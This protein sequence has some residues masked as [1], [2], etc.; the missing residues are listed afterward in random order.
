[1]KTSWQSESGGF[2]RRWSD[3]LESDQSTSPVV[4]EVLTG[5][6]E[7]F[8]PPMPDLPHIVCWARE[9]GS[10]PGTI[11]GAYRAP[12]SVEQGRR[13]SLE[14]ERMTANPEIILKCLQSL[15]VSVTSWMIG[16]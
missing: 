11:G 6:Y 13:D 12:L 16:W 2:V 9:S 3:L 7:R 8:V 4:R 14:F 15:R 10:F 1:M 5:V